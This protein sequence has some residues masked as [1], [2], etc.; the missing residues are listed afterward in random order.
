MKWQNKLTKTELKHFR[1]A[2]HGDMTLIGFRQNRQ[3]Q[4]ELDPNNEVCQEC[5]SIAKQLGIE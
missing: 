4:K 3:R 5:K 1:F 2:T